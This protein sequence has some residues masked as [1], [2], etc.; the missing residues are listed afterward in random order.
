MAGVWKTCGSTGDAATGSCPTA[1]VVVGVGCTRQRSGE[2]RRTLDPN[3]RAI[4]RHARHFDI[5]QR[6]ILLAAEDVGVAGTAARHQRSYLRNPQA[7]DGARA[8]K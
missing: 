8:R 1:L 5:E 4:S 6:A 7:I 2:G 3:A